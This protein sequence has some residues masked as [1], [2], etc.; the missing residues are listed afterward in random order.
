MFW[1][2]FELICN[3]IHA[4]SRLITCLHYFLLRKKLGWSCETQFAVFKLS[5][6]SH[7]GDFERSTS[8]INTHFAF[9]GLTNKFQSICH[10][11]R[12][13]YNREKLCA[14]LAFGFVLQENFEHFHMQIVDQFFFFCWN[15]AHH[16][17]LLNAMLNISI[18]CL[19]LFLASTNDDIPKSTNTEFKCLK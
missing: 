3:V 8:W 11:I 17:L 15:V 5:I 14:I 10:T 1:R 2:S 7:Y 6:S 4:Q 12:M 13:E 16:D 19:A 18:S 9:K